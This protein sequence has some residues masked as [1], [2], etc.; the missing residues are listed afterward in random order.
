MKLTQNDL[1]DK[2][3]RKADYNYEKNNFKEYFM[4]APNGSPYDSS[5]VKAFSKVSYAD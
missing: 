4:E 3:K 1:F 5:D 2:N